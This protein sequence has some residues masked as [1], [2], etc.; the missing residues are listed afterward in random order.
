[1]SLGRSRE[2]SIASKDVQGEETDAPPHEAE[3]VERCIA[4][5]RRGTI[6]SVAGSMFAVKMNA[7]SEVNAGLRR[8]TVVSAR[9]SCNLPPL[10]ISDLSVTPSVETPANPPSF[11]TSNVTDVLKEP[12]I[13]LHSLSFFA[14]AF[15]FDSYL[16]VI[17]DFAKDIGVAAKESVHAIAILSAAD[18][19]GRFFVPF[20]SDYK[21]MSTELLLGLSYLV[22]GVIAEASPFLTGKFAF[23]STAALLG[24]PGGYI[25]V[26][27]SEILSKEHGAKNLPMAY[28]IVTLVTAIGYFIRP[29]IIGK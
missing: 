1:M 26:G 15:F 25:V 22:L 2:N 19:V 8:S 6:M 27:T 13:Y 3:N 17:L 9:S 10:I 29:P 20:L 11:S 21:V 5:E 7:L 12:R 28:G 4:R 23:M 16:A 14:F 18:T 24:I